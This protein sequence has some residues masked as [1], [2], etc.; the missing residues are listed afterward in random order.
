[1]NRVYRGALRAAVVGALLGGV[2]GCVGEV[3]G[4]GERKTGDSCSGWSTEQLRQHQ[5]ALGHLGTR[6]R[7]DLDSKAFPIPDVAVTT[8]D[9]AP[10]DI[11]RQDYGACTEASVYFA[12]GFEMRNSALV[13]SSWQ[14]LGQF[15]ALRSRA[16]QGEADR[17][18]PGAP[19]PD[20]HRTPSVGGDPFRTVFCLVSVDGH[21]SSWNLIAISPNC[22]SLLVDLQLDGS[23]FSDNEAD[24][25]L[26]LSHVAD[27]WLGDLEADLASVPCSD[28][29]GTPMPVVW[30]PQRALTQ[31]IG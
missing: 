1:M 20:A 28:Y 26:V 12:A 7:E 30:S 21:C 6:L 3:F 10:L 23:M 24:A 31:T 17:R 4:G 5:S 2:T 25:T 11:L 8:F 18:M 27:L 14:H 13:F 15:V 9:S 29:S 19:S 16:A 22:R